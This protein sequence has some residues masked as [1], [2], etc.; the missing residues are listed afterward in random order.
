MGIVFEQRIRHFDRPIKRR[1]HRYVAKGLR[2]EAR[3]KMKGLP[4]R[5]I[6]SEFFFA[7]LRLRLA[8][9]EG[10]IEDLEIQRQHARLDFEV[11]RSRLLERKRKALAR[12]RARKVTAD[13]TCINLWCRRR[14]WLDHVNSD[15]EAP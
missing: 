15:L 2:E 12:L 7:K 4:S 1:H 10:Q 13:R 11:L 6:S 3:R 14:A 5:S 9:W 8:S